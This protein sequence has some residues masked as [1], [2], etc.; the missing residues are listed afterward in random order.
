MQ[1]EHPAGSCPSGW[2]VCLIEECR[3]HLSARCSVT[4]LF[5]IQK[6][7]KINCWKLVFLIQGLHVSRTCFRR[8]LHSDLKGPT[9]FY[10]G[11]PLWSSWLCSLERNVQKALHAPARL[12]SFVSST[13]GPGKRFYMETYFSL[14]ICSGSCELTIVTVRDFSE[15][16]SAFY[17]NCFWGNLIRLMHHISNCFTVGM[18]F[19]YESDKGLH[20]NPLLKV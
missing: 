2:G 14:R 11:V 3:N 13:C 9:V 17:S 18:V 20:L 6:F 10:G 5:Q 12:S 19:I 16:V 15:A 1:P 8:P 4:V 7:E